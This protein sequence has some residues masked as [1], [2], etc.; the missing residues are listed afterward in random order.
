ML[1]K[2]TRHTYSLWAIGALVLMIIVLSLM[3]SKKDT[4]EDAEDAREPAETASN[5]H[6][7]MT[8]QYLMLRPSRDFSV[9]DR[10]II[11]PLYK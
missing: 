3:P 7:G 1:E 10:G 6:P 2:L 11:R 5:Q 4:F 8:S 9:E